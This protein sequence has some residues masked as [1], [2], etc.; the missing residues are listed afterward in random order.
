MK[1]QPRKLSKVHDR[2]RTVTI[3]ASI[4]ALWADTD[5]VSMEYND[6]ENCL[7]I[8]PID[9]PKSI[10]TPADHFGAAQ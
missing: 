3:P 7:K 8:T 4:A 6:R 9:R 1:F 5:M 10:G 2:W